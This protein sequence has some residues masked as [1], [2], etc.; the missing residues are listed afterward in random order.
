MPRIA[1]V[2][3]LCL[4]DIHHAN[5]RTIHRQ[6]GGD[7]LFAALGLRLWVDR[8]GVVSRLGVGYD[9]GVTQRLSEAGIDTAGVKPSAEPCVHN[10]LDYTEAQGRR[11]TRLAGSHRD[12]TPSP[13]VWPPAWSDVT[14]VHLA[15]FPVDLQ[16]QWVDFLSPRRIAI[17]LDPHLD[18]EENERSC[19]REAL[20]RCDLFIPSSL[21]LKQLFPGAPLEEAAQ[22]VDGWCRAG[23]IVKCGERGTYVPRLKRWLAP[24][25]VNK[26]ADETGAGDAYGAAFLAG[27]MERHDVVEAH[28]RGAVAAAFIIEGQGGMHTL[29]VSRE[30]AA[31]RLREWMGND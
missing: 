6:W 21:E 13:A 19:L 16:A 14:A 9:V 18:G 11:L 30:D 29:A 23:A 17:S 1:V 24:C 28:R 15:P 3:N 5:G 7:A 27:W 10:R 12:N 2:G 4:D 25:P 8:A 26:M 31:R 22:E 20:N